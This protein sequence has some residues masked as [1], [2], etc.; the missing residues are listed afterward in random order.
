MTKRTEDYIIYQGEEGRTSDFSLILGRG[1]GGRVNQAAGMGDGGKE[2][3]PAISY[4][5]N[6]VLQQSLL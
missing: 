4:G 2:I 5:K 6:V 1:G 3:F